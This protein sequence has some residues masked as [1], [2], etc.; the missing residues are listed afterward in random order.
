MKQELFIKMGSKKVS[1]ASSDVR[2]TDYYHLR[3][4]QCALNMQI[5]LAMQTYD[6]ETRIRLE[7]EMEEINRQIKCISG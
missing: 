7:K 1:N 6:I 5:R 3:Q 4:Q 2:K